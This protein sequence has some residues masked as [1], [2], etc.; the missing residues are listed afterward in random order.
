MDNKV[1]ELTKEEYIRLELTKAYIAQKSNN[2]ANHIGGEVMSLT[3]VILTGCRY[4]DKADNPAEK[5]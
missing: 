1:P 3:E 4:G 5:S 2:S